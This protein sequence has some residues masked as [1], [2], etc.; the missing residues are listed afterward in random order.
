MQISSDPATP[1]N[2]FGMATYLEFEGLSGINENPFDGAVKEEPSPQANGLTQQN[3]DHQPQASSS[4]QANGR[5]QS[6][7]QSH[8][9]SRMDGSPSVLGSGSNA[10]DLDEDDDGEG[11]EERGRNKVRGQARFLQQQ[12][13]PGFSGFDG[14]ALSEGD[15]ESTA[16]RMDER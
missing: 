7:S 5:R 12:H 14:S 13:Q 4:S 16:L 2:H 6:V 10:S 9:D 15:D 8:S 1:S 11:E 3:G